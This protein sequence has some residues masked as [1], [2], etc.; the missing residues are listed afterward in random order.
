MRVHNLCYKIAKTY[1]DEDHV[2]MEAQSIYKFIE[3]RLEE[4]ARLE[5]AKEAP[6]RRPDSK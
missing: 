1:A 4:A 6:P 5:R 2:F 3:E